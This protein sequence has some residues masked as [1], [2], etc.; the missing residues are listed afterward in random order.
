MIQRTSLQAKL[1]AAL[2]APLLLLTPQQSQAEK[3]EYTDTLEKARH[4]FNWQGEELYYKIKVNDADAAHAVIR[5]GE[6]RLLKDQP[7]VALSAKA[8]SVGLFDSIYPMDDR[9]NTF[10]DPHNFTPLRSE[11][12]FK[13]AGKARTY[14]VD[15]DHNTFKAKVHK[16]WHK[17]EKNPKEKERKYTR[18]IPGLTH[19]ALSWFFDLRSKKDFTPDEVYSYY[20]D[21]GWK[22]SRVDLT[23]IGEERVLT[24]MGWFNSTRFDFSREDLKATHKIKDG[25]HTEPT[26]KVRKP[27]KPFGSVWLSNDARRIPVK[28][29]V[30]STLGTGEVFLAKYIKPSKKTATKS[31]E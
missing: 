10:F 13:E 21:D 20:I 3:P 9:A 30:V 18:A 6:V 2:A 7:Y 29:Q 16:I 12:F 31:K 14:K 19:D 23:V 8:K 24:P 28:I 1:L 25:K 15:Y 11:K 4:A 27:G 5:V 26:L 17:S 22:L